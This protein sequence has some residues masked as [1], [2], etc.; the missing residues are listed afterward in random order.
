[1][2][3]NEIVRY[4]KL[5]NEEPEKKLRYIQDYL[6]DVPVSFEGFNA[7]LRRMNADIGDLMSS[8]ELCEPGNGGMC[9]FDSGNLSE[10]EVEEIGFRMRVPFPII[11]IGKDSLPAFTTKGY[12]R[13]LRWITP[14]TGY[15]PDVRI[16][17]S[18]EFKASIGIVNEKGDKIDYIEISFVNSIF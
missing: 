8:V 1:M 2:D 10:E 17:T 11:L 18:P 9:V 7:E 6:K 14:G 16:L 15:Y 3:L 4:Y 13:L 12:Q 5:W